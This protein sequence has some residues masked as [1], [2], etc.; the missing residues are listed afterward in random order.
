[1]VLHSFTYIIIVVSFLDEEVK[2]IRICHGIHK[3]PRGV[4]RSCDAHGLERSL[5]Q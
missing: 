3:I 4:T 5:L 1:M 2:G